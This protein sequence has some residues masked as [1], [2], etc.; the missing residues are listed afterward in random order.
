MNISEI[1]NFETFRIP[2]VSIHNKGRVA[3]LRH[4]QKTVD[5]KEVC[6]GNKRVTLGV[7]RPCNSVFI[8][9]FV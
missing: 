4:E 6:M 8:R 1:N 5:K 9:R 7:C 2:T 3:E